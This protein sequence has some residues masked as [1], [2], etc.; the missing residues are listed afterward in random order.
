MKSQ[1]KGEGKGSEGEGR[2]AANSSKYIANV[3]PKALADNSI[4]ISIYIISKEG[5][6]RPK[7]LADNSIVKKN[8]EGVGY[9]LRALFKRSIPT[10]NKEEN[11]RSMFVSICILNK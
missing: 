2:G 1:T 11:V 10:A 3:R 8:L 5:N 9:F 6:V 4:Y 7:A